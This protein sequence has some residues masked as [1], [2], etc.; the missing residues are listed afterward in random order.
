MNKRLTIL[1][2]LILPVWITAQVSFEA[3]TDARQVVLNSYFDVTFTLRNADGDNF[4]PPSFDDFTVLAGPSRSL[5][6]TIMNGAAVSKELLFSYTL[7]PKRKG[8]F[9]IGSARMT[10][11]GKT[12]RTQPLTVEIVETKSLSKDG[13]A[14]GFT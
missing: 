6:T 13:P 7:R 11:N 8:K 4:T 3:S 12:L 1:I 2:L 10:V 5:S 14:N 9:T